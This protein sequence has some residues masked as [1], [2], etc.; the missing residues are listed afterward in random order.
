MLSRRFAAVLSLALLTLV[1][2]GGS[3]APPL[4]QVEG[5]V[6]MDGKPLPGVIVVFKPEKG[7]PAT[8]QTDAEGKY[9]LTYR[10]GVPGAKTGPNTVSMEYPIG[11][12]GPAIS[13]K[14]STK[15]E[16]KADVKGGSNKFDFPLQSGGE[17]AA[18]PHAD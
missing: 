1:G 15:S 8:G 12:S 6:T 3:D 5:V 9:K 18:P 14:Y 13:A 2:C 7:R 11:G 4:G 10:A 16:L 17:A